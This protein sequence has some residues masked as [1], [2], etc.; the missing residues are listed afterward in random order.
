MTA[1]RALLATMAVTCWP[2]HAADE[3]P[4]A[5][6]E[7]A[8][9]A[10]AHREL[11]TYDLQIEA[12]IDAGG[13]SL[14]LSASV[15]CDAQRRCLRSFQ[16]STTLVTPRLSLIVDAGSRT[17]TVTR[18]RLSE[19][20]QSP[21]N[22]AA[23]FEDWLARGGKLS[24]GALTSWGR[25]WTLSDRASP[26]A[27]IYVDPESRRIHRFVY[28]TPRADGGLTSVDIRYTWRDAARLNPDEFDTGRFVREVAGTIAPAEA[29]ARY[30]IISADGR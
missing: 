17:I 9:I 28:Q 13:E 18:Q 30:R 8:L 27:E 3:S 23:A 5:R 20:Q 22:P 1:F 7:F 10:D 15:K 29:Y 12:R 14:P 24:G 2:A 11:Q 6:E 26:R 25:H 19:T 21:A 16:N 4:G